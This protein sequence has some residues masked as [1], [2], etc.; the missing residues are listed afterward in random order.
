VFRLLDEL[1]DKDAAVDDGGVDRKQGS[2][3]VL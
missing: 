1:I 2:S 3:Y